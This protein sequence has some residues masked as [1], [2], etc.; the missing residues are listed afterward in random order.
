MD[1]YIIYMFHVC[2]SYGHAYAFDVHGYL[3]ITF[4]LCIYNLAKLASIASNNANE[5]LCTAATF[6]D[7]RYFLLSCT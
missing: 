2:V 6:G 7:F 4:F 5:G 3:H 1:V